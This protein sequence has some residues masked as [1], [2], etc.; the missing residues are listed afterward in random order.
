MLDFASDLA[1]LDLRLK[2]IY[3]SQVNPAS[4]S[5]HCIMP[6]IFESNPNKREKTVTKT[7][8]MKCPI[9]FEFG[10]SVNVNIRMAMVSANPATVANKP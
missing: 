6:A 10:A 9:L 4:H 8:A 1:L 3:R 7:S 5:N 2:S